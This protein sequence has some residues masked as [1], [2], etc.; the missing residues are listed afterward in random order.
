MKYLNTRDLTGIGAISDTT[1]KALTDS[2]EKHKSETN[3]TTNGVSASY[4]LTLP[5]ATQTNQD[6]DF[7]ALVVLFG[8]SSL[9]LTPLEFKNNAWQLAEDSELAERIKT[10]A[11]TAFDEIHGEE[12]LGFAHV[13]V[14][15]DTPSGDVST[16][17]IDLAP[18]FFLTKGSSP[19]DDQVIA[20]TFPGGHP[21][22][23]EAL[24]ST[25]LCGIAQYAMRNK[26]CARQHD[27]LARLYWTVLDKTNVTHDRLSPFVGKFNYDGT[28]LDCCSGTG[29]FAR[30]ANEGGVKAKYSS[31]DYSV[32]MTNIL[33]SKKLYEQPFIIGPMQEVL[34]KAAVHD[35]VVCFGSFHLLQ[36]FDFLSAISQ[37]FLRA[38]KSVTFDVD[39][40]S[41]GYIS[42]FPDWSSEKAWEKLEYNHNNV[43]NALRF[44][45]PVGWK[46]VLPGERRFAYHSLLMKEDVY[47]RSFRFEK[48]E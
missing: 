8:Q 2:V 5:T 48:I 4:K 36:P 33:G 45:V 12:Y 32:E 43:E 30:F 6:G 40:L 34:T 44:G 46:A 25:R 20:K 23:I 29:E 39:D 22:F 19:W 17:S 42:K 14:H 7:S 3:G 27:R 35:H 28:V 26:G 18:S 10:L 16:T 11:K 31:L 1:L 37:M 15:V 9:A 13:N 38:R 47:T 21:A 41:E 24:L